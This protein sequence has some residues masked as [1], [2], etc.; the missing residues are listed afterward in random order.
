[1][2][3]ADGV[4]GVRARGLDAHLAVAEASLSLDLRDDLQLAEVDLDPLVDVA[5][6]LRL[7][8]PRTSVLLDPYPTPSTTFT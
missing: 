1:M 2:L 7:G 5:C 8:A 6:D 3:W 4:F